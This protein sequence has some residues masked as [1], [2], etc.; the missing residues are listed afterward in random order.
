MYLVGIFLVQ[1]ICSRFVCT[2][3]Y[4]GAT[5][6]LFF[7]TV[8]HV[9]CFQNKFYI[10]SKLNRDLRED[11]MKLFAD[12]VAEIHLSTLMR[13]CIASFKA[14]IAVMIF[15]NG[16]FA[17]YFELNFPLTLGKSMAYVCLTSL[18][19]CLIFYHV[20]FSCSALLIKA[21]SMPFQVQPSTMASVVK[22]L[23]SLRPGKLCLYV[24]ISSRF[25]TMCSV[26]V[27]ALCVNSIRLQSCL[28]L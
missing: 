2:Q 12:C 6:S 9:P 26:C 21:H 23:Y 27:S 20:F 22:G 16:Y 13:E 28:C 17:C 15:L 3:L 1:C 24:N 5:V 14:L 4:P 8:F 7:S 11:L 10:E 19:C 25:Q 18:C